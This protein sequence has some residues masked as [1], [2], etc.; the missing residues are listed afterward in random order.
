[1]ELSAKDREKIVF[2]NDQNRL[3]AEDIERMVKKAERFAEDDKKFKELDDARH[4]LEGFIY[5][6][7][8]QI[9]GEK[10]LGSK[11][12]EDEKTKIVEAIAEKIKWLDENQSE[13]TE[14]YRKQKEF[15][16]VVQP[17]ISSHDKTWSIPVFTN[18][19]NFLQ[20]N[21]VISLFTSNL[22]FVKD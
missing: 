21:I 13:T 14:D 10:G 7:R 3:T 8:N 4:E 5:S 22:K 1:M 18:N 6:L 2:S 20:V 19:S 15:E 16:E 9:V 11:L 12:S 17:I